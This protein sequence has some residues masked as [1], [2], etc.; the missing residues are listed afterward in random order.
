MGALHVAQVA[1]VLH[2]DAAAAAVD[3]EP[4]ESRHQPLVDV[5]HTCRER[6]RLG[7]AQKVVVGLERGAASRRVHDDRR[8][9]RHRLHH[10]PG[11]PAGGI[12]EPGMHVERA[13]AVASPPRNRIRHPDRCHHL[14]RGAVGLALP[15]VHHASGEQPRVGTGVRRSTATTQR[16]APEPEAGR[17]EADPL[18]ERQQR[19]PAEQQPMP[20]EHRERQPLP[21]RCDETFVGECLTGVL[22]EPSERHAARARRLAAA[23]LHARLH[24]V[25]ELVVGLRAAPLDGPHRVDTATRRERLLACRPE[26]RAV[27]EAQTARDARREFVVVEP[28]IHRAGHGTYRHW[29]VHCGASVSPRQ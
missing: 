11:Q 29:A 2:D 20:A 26:R 10:P 21:S 4:V 18:G 3:D 28:E 25:H 27:R 23:A 5:D 14:G 16:E 22:H 24:E 7:G 9:A 15:R 8:I 1:R 12:V 13:A 17:H 6:R 19:G